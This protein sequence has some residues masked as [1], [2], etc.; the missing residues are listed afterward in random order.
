MKKLNIILISL[1]IIGLS[2]TFAF[3]QGD[4]VRKSLK[5]GVMQVIGADT[6]ITI[7]YSRPGVKGRKIWGDLVPFGMYPGNKYSDNK[8]YPWRAGADESTTIEI[9][10][11]VF[12]EGKK[13]AGGKY[14]IHMIPS[15]KEWVVIFNKN[16]ELW[17]SYEYDETEDALRVNVKPVKGTFQEWLTF[18]FDNLSASSALVVLSWEELKIP[19]KITLVGK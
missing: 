1:I 5:A 4:D 14:S 17:G 8:P 19:F 7:S 10:K 9:S 6:E 13:L 15:E 18:T 16:N 12:V 11:D 3:A 2:F